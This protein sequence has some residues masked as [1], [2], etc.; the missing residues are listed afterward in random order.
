MKEGDGVEERDE[1]WNDERCVGNLCID[2]K[3][4]LSLLLVHPKKSQGPGSLLM[5]PT[6]PL[7]QLSRDQSRDV[8]MHWHCREHK[9]L[10]RSVVAKLAP[11]RDQRTRRDV[12]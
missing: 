4:L 6:T 7:F 2:A 10:A 5:A 9:S 12:V 1:Y 3:T 8:R 11:G